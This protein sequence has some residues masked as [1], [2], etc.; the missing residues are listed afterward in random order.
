DDRGR[1]EDSPDG[2]KWGLDS[3][4]AALALEA[5][6]QSGLLAAD[7]GSRAA[8]EG[9]VERIARAQDVLA[10][11]PV[12]VRLGDRLLEN[13]RPQVELPA[14]IDVGVAAFDGV[15]GENHSFQDLMRVLLHE[16]PILEGPRLRF[17]R[18]AEQVHRLS[19]RVLRNE[20]PLDARRETGAAAAPDSR[21]L[22]L[23][24]QLRRRP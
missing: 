16:K 20:A 5:L 10:Q 15:G 1:D 21:L 12:A 18:V 7:V 24:G 22:D 6:D 2:R 17:V 13:A 9:D 4:L 11:V 8:V 14:T 19:A 23:L 3:R